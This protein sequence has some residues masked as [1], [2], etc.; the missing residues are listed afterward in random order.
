[1]QNPSCYSPN[2]AGEL[3]LPRYDIIQNEVRQ[4]RKKCNPAFSSEKTVLFLVDPQVGFCI[5]GASL[6]VNGAEKDIERI[7]NFIYRNLERIDEIRVSL[8]TH[9]VFQ[10]HTP[11]FWVN[12]QN[13]NPNPFSIITLEN[14]KE[15]K[16]RPYAE[17]I[18]LELIESYLEQLETGEK[19]I[20][21]T[22]EYHTQKGSVDNAVVPM[23]YEALFFYS[24]MTG[25]EIKW[26][27]KGESLWTENYSVLSPE[28]SKLYFKDGSLKIVGNFNE[29]LMTE[30]MAFDRVYVAGEAASHCVKATLEDMLKVIKKDK[31]RMPNNSYDFEENKIYILEDCMSPV[32]P[33]AGS[34]DFPA[35]AKEALEKFKLA[36][37]RVVK[38]TDLF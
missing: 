15:K 31:L 34:P 12:D 3:Y 6:Y 20:L 36:G 25:K 37:M 11:G 26:I 13:E 18:T 10:I 38:S 17:W 28:V 22:W 9:T 7:C 27:T 2:R 5:P 23:L 16:W 14:V 29:K 19:Y 4:L 32:Q 21:I 30:L 35:I 1:M 24:L 33:T 8:D